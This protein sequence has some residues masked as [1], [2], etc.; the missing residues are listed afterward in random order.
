[1]SQA[2]SVV[3]DGSRPEPRLSGAQPSI[4]ATSKR[5]VRSHDVPV[6]IPAAGDVP[7]GI[8]AISNVSCPAMIPVAGR[9]VIH[10]TLRNLQALGFRRFRIAVARAGMFVEDFVSSAIGADHVDFVVSSS[11]RGIGG[12]VLDLLE[13]V[14]TRSALVVLGD[15]YVEFADTSFLEVDETL[16]FVRASA[17]Q[18]VDDV[19][20]CYLADVEL[21]REVA[22]SAAVAG[23]ITLSTILGGVDERATVRA[24]EATQWVDAGRPDHPPARDAAPLVGRHFNQLSFDSTFGTVTKRSTNVDKFVDEIAYL[25]LLPDDVAV[26]FPRVLHASTDRSDPHLTME[27][28]AYPSLADVFLFED[29]DDRVWRRV[30]DHLHTVLESSMWRH[31]APMS[32]DDVHAMYLDK[33]RARLTSITEPAPLVRLIAHEGTI[34]VNGVAVQNFSTLWPALARAT[35]ALTEVEATIVHGDLCLSNILYDL[36]ADIVKLI[37]PRG[38]FGRTGIFGDPRYDVAKLYHSTYGL[39]DCIVN[40]LF[41][42]DVD[43]DGFEMHLDIRS[44]PRHGH[45]RSAFEAVFFERFDRREIL[46]IAGLIFASLPALHA[47]SPSRQIAMYGRALQLVHEALA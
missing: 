13:G 32:G 7:D 3:V 33:P 30:F 40:D 14:R 34:R 24:V 16:A 1:M 36:R 23:P 15:R 12:T 42:V 47:E 28:Y 20:A 8:V 44:Q 2:K 45:V 6:L 11:H 35:K 22:K 29:V 21:A 10:W 37:D 25:G 9:P 19:G 26:L 38:S 31:R 18:P 17:E 41:E 39:Y 27:Y 46:L 4:G 43:V 5:G